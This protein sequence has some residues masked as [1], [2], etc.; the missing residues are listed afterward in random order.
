MFNRFTVKNLS[1]GYTVFFEKSAKTEMER[2]V[3][4]GLIISQ[5]GKTV[6][7]QNGKKIVS[8]KDHALIIPHGASYES[9]CTESGRFTVINFLLNESSENKDILSF[10][11]MQS[12]ALNNLCSRFS[13]LSRL[14]DR[15]SELKRFSVF[16]EIVSILSEQN[17]TDSITPVLTKAKKYVHDRLDD[18]SL[19]CK[20]IA[21]ELGISEIYLRKLFTK[22]LHIS[23]G[24]YIREAR[25]AHAKELLVSSGKSISEIAHE[26]GYDSVYSFS[27]AFKTQ[28]GIP[29]T[30]YKARYII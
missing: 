14:E 9:E 23:L 28:T 24:K 25:I 22:E 7:R 12:T 19:V 29:P 2:R 16:Y 4:N 15:G 21:H 3:W 20:S 30:A 18:P 8:D 11:V 26:S 1:K 10:R 5:G 17:S 13:E 6:Y 27:R